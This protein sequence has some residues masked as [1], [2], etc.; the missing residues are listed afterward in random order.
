LTVPVSVFEVEFSTI[1]DVAE[2][3]PDGVTDA[4]VNDADTSLGRPD[5]DRL[6]APGPMTPRPATFAVTLPL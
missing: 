3:V 5:T 4:G 2:P 1:A 6:T